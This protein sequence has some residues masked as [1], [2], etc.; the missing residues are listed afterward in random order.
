MKWIAK[1]FELHDDKG[2]WLASIDH[3]EDGWMVYV[4]DKF[5][6]D[7]N[8]AFGPFTTE[9]L[10]KAAAIKVIERTDNG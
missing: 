4:D 5:V 8:N 10:A 9:E 6:A 1:R 7:M 3:D 2:E